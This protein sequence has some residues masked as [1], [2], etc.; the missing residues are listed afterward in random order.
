MSY[1]PFSDK[2]N[3]V[4]QSEDGEGLLSHTQ[5][6]Y[7]QP[8]RRNN[9]LW[10]ILSIP[11][12]SLSS[13]VFGIWIG[14][15]FVA[16]PAKLCPSYV[17]HYSPIL[18]DIDTS[19]QPVMFNGSF[20][21]ENAFR[22]KAGPEVD[23]AWGSLGVH[24]RSL[25]L[26]ASEAEKSGLTS[27]HVQINE[28]YGGGFPVNLEGL[29]HLHCLNLVRQSLYYN[30]DY[31]HEK[32]EGAF[33]NDDNVVQ[34]HVSHCLDIIRQ[35][36]MCQVD[37]GVLGQVWW[38]KSKPQAFVDFNTEHKCKNFDAIRQWAEERQ[39]PAGGPP[40]FLQKPKESDVLE[41][42]P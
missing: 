8:P 26:P 32:G 11:V 21:K 9:I 12:I 6:N 37:T 4:P 19:Y 40:D 13:V 35:Q 38:D 18:N 29:H 39:M 27:A 5:Q 31:Y 33:V 1:T 41:S 14:A 30:Y 20:M 42:I 34:Y 25:A 3:E 17:Q 15:R 10:Y 23:E 16:N 36:L 22:L 7:K 24:Y 28:K 2:Y